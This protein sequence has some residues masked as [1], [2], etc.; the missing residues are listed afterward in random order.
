MV[1]NLKGQLFIL[2]FMKLKVSFSW[3]LS[4]LDLMISW[5]LGSWLFSLENPLENKAILIVGNSLCW[6]SFL[7][8]LHASRRREKKT[9]RIETDK[10][11]FSLLNMRVYFLENYSWSGRNVQE[12]W[13]TLI[14][15]NL[16]QELFSHI[17]LSHISNLKQAENITDFTGLFQLLKTLRKPCWNPLTKNPVSFLGYCSLKSAHFERNRRVCS[18]F[19]PRLEAWYDICVTEHSFYS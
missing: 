2:Y 3:I 7:L 13:V 14:L 1:F 5:L 19:F 8:S 12:L 10:I 4:L 18:W 9:D 17:S 16:T 11:Q 6:I 15:Q